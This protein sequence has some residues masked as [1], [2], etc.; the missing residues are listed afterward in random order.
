M[1]CLNENPS[2]KILH[3]SDTE[4]YKSY[5]QYHSEPFLCNCGPCKRFWRSTLF[6]N[7]DTLLNEQRGETLS[8][9]DNPKSVAVGDRVKISGKPG[10]QK[11]ALF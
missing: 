9:S 8:A 6:N 10:G 5:V 2:V 7:S 3:F 1:Q 11:N 4:W